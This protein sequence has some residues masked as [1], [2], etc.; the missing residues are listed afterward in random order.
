MNRYGKPARRLT[1]WLGSDDGS[2]D[3]MGGYG[4][5]ITREDLMVRIGC[6]V[7]QEDD[8]ELEVFILPDL[9]PKIRAAMDLA[10]EA[11]EGY[12]RGRMRKP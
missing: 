8:E 1:I 2:P 5:D 4:Y 11:R 10:D 3:G 9:F 6:P 7:P 12:L